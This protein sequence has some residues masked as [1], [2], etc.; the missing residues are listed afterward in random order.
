MRI[1]DWSSDV[2]SSDLLSAPLHLALHQ[3]QPGRHDGAAITLAQSRPDEHIGDACFIFKRDDDRVAFTRPL[4]DQHNTRAAH[5][6]TIFRGRNFR[7]VHH[8]LPP[9][10]RTEASHGISLQSSEEQTTELPSLLR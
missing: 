8:Y 4:T 5:P 7:T 6:R 3:H 2:C 1:S 9:E 10:D